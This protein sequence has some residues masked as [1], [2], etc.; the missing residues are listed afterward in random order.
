MVRLAWTA[1]E[2]WGFRGCAHRNW[3]KMWARRSRAEFLNPPIWVVS[4]QGGSAARSFFLVR[5]LPSSPSSD[6][7][8][9]P[10][11]PKWALG[12]HQSTQTSL[13]LLFSHHQSSRKATQSSKSS[14]HL[15]RWGARPLF[16]GPAMISGATHSFSGA[17]A[18][19]PS[20]TVALAHSSLLFVSAPSLDNDNKIYVRFATIHIIKLM[21]RC[22]Q[23]T[24]L[25]V[26]QLAAM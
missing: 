1:T 9:Q 4:N 14:V 22:T 25:K 10:R 17:R 8:S 3:S 23:M 19:E 2:G 12:P 6:H 20:A 16:I 7:R 15:S 21:G 18:E 11:A 5:A 13:L 24:P 26:G